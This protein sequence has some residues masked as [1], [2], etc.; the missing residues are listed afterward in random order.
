M[1]YR[2]I[3]LS[4]YLYYTAA[5]PPASKRRSTKFRG[6]P[7]RMLAMRQTRAWNASDPLCVGW[8]DCD[9]CTVLYYTIL[10]YTMLCYTIVDTMQ[11]VLLLLY[12]TMAGQ[13]RAAEPPEPLEAS[14]L[15]A[16]LDSSRAERPSM[17]S[18]NRILKQADRGFP[19]PAASSKR[20]SEGHRPRRS[21]VRIPRPMVW[22][23]YLCKAT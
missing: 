16:A 22:A 23:H 4:S 13:G 1:I 17:T 5:R 7:V 2:S 18:V 11:I 21:R 14:S 3:Y 15:Q 19:D 8:T 9:R 12:Y 20:R 10:Y 6:K